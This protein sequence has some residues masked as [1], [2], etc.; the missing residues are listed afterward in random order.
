MCVRACVCSCEILVNRGW[1]PRQQMHPSTRPEGQV[2]GDVALTAILRKT[3][4]VRAYHQFLFPP[5]TAHTHTHFPLQRMP[6]APKNDAANNHWNYKDID[7]MSQVAGTEPILVDADSS[8]PLSSL[9]T[10]ELE[11]VELAHNLFPLYSYYS[12]RWT[13][14]RPNKSQPPQ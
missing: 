1:V 10:R 12:S 7:G 11:A 4:K 6:F 14:R 9:T 2:E 3:E 5:H 8:E 13:H